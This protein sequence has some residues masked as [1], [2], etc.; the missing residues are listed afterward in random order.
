MKLAPRQRAA[1]VAAAACGIVVAAAVPMLL[2]RSHPAA[3]PGAPPA[4]ATVPPTCLPTDVYPVTPSPA[5][6]QEVLVPAAPAAAQICRYAGFGETTPSAHLVAGKQLNTAQ[7][8]QLATALNSGNRL[9]PGN[10]P[11]SCPDDRGATDDITFTYRSRQPVHVVVSLQGC[12]L[13]N[14]GSSIENWTTRTT[15][16]LLATFVGTPDLVP[17]PGVPSASP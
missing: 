12:Q 2:S 15:R 6:P 17:T 9:A 16:E 1:A 3:T 14:N 11:P 8:G 4:S 10:S 13:A 5:G 7:A